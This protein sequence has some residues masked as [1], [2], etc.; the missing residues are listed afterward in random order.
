MNHAYLTM[1]TMVSDEQRGERDRRLQGRRLFF[2][3][4]LWGIVA[5]FELAAFVDSLSGTVSQ[6][7]V[8]CT[9]SCTNLQLSAAGISTLQHLGFS[10]GYYI[11]FYLTILLISILLSYAVAVV[12]L[13]RRSDDW[14]ALLVSL[15]LLGFGPGI[16]SNGVRFSQWFGPAMA[17]HVSSLFDTIN[18]TI[19]VLS[20]FLFPTGRFVPRWTRWIM[21]IQIGLGAFLVF[22]PRFASDLANN[23][24]ILVFFGVLLSLVIAQVYRYRRV[25]TPAQRQQTKWIV[26]SL[27]VTIILTVGILTVPQV[28]LPALAQPGTLLA[29]ASDIVANALL[30]FIPISFGVAILRYRL[31]DIDILINRTLVYLTLTA[32]LAL[33][34]FGSIIAVQSLLRSVINQNSTVAIVVSTLAI[35]A[36]FQPLRHRIQAIIDRRFYRRKYDAAHTLEAF[37]ATLRNEVDLVTLREHLLTIVQETMQ[38]AHVSLWLRKSEHDGKPGRT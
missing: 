15:M 18:L 5:I 2:A 25:S 34:Y 36:L 19:L 26:Y 33:I 23:I 14:M 27:T 12:L 3:R 9:S 29:S 20:F 7:Q 22:F 32:I 37:S 17:G 1:P 4:L 11:A 38:P 28:T 16:L 13:W 8:R 6:L 30:T 21:C 24:A 10:P 35:A 31:Y